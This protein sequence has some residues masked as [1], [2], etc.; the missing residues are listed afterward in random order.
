MTLREMI[1]AIRIVD[2]CRS[3]KVAILLSYDN[4]DYVSTVMM[5]NLAKVLQYVIALASP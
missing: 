4:F 1:F 5:I 3:I 2:E